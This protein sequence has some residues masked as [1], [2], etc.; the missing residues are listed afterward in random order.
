MWLS[1]P[2]VSSQNSNF[3]PIVDAASLPVVNDQD[4]I[5]LAGRAAKTGIF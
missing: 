4:D 1:P 5:L 2:R 3:V